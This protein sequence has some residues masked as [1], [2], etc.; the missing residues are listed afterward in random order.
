MFFSEDLP[1]KFSSVASWL[2]KPMS[3]AQIFLLCSRPHWQLFLSLST[4]P[5]INSMCPRGTHHF[6]F[7][8]CSSH[9]PYSRKLYFCFL[10]DSISKKESFS[11]MSRY[12]SRSLI[13]ATCII[14]FNPCNSLKIQSLF[15]GRRWTV[16]PRSRASNSSC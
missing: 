11:W 9:V 15:S 16:S 3:L 1:V 12:Y 2:P 13:H 7:L 10:N 4:L 8:I 5:S 14:S 6:H